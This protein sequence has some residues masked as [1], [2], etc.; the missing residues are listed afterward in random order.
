MAD[1]WLEYIRKFDNLLQEAF[2]LC[3]R[4]S[5]QMLYNKLHGDGTFGPSPFI[6]IDIDLKDSKVIAKKGT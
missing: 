6:E 5:M 3:A 1:E 4:N 2:C